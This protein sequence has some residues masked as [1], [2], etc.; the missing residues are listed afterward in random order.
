MK[1]PEGKNLFKFNPRGKYVYSIQKFLFK[2]F[3]NILKD[4]LHI[5]QENNFSQ[6]NFSPCDLSFES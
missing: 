1:F 4:S 3:K 2:D 5:L 6:E